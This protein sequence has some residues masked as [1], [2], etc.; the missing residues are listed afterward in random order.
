[1]KAPAQL[2]LTWCALLALPT[3]LPLLPA[4]ADTADEAADEGAASGGF[5]RTTI[6]AQGRP[7]FQVDGRAF[8]FI[9]GN[10]TELPWLDPAQQ[11]HELRWAHDSGLEVVRVWGVD[12]AENADQMAGRLRG[13][14]DRASARGLR[15][16]IAL[17]HN[18]HQP[19]WLKGSSTFHAVPGDARPNDF[20][21]NG[22]GFYSRDCGPGLACL[23]DAWL[24]WG[25]TAYYRPYATR[26]VSLLADHPAVFSWDIANEVTG[27]SADPWIVGRVTS[28]YADMAARIKAADP[29]HMVTTGLIS[30]SW[31]AMTDAQRDAVY[32]S[33]NVDYLTVHEYDGAD[34][35]SFNMSAQDDEVWRANR[36]YGKPIVVE[37]LGIAGANAAQRTTD[38]VNRRFSPADRAFE[39]QGIVWWGL[40]SPQHP[41]VTDGVW[42]PQALGLYDWF[43]GFWRGWAGTLRAESNGT[44]A[45]CLALGPGDAL[46][47]NQSKGSCDGQYSLAMQGDGNLV[48]YRSGGP[49]VWASCTQSGTTHGAFMQGDGNLVI[50]ATTGA[51]WSTRTGQANSRLFFESG[52]LVMR[53]TNDAVVWTSGTWCQ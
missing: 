10:L 1:M 25:Y 3:L 39:A 24:D 14:L 44:G 8:R 35:N 2:P 33:A 52:G 42:S 51:L 22:N 18:Y 48:L 6:D 16:T 26:L 34:G 9:G 20:T 12:D 40:A 13:V 47:T 27:S 38:Y 11:D 5:V 43:Q 46:G 4:C 49:A 41:E 17:T 30:T 19:N 7:R 37:E 45:R 29:N 15:V 50:Y 31:A 36:R 53:A 23:D 21:R 32:R 28:F